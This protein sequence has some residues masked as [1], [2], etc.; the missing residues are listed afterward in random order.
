VDIGSADLEES[1]VVQAFGDRYGDAT[2]TNSQG[3][4]F[5]CREGEK[6]L[7]GRVKWVVFSVHDFLTLAAFRLFF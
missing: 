6:L 5:L 4:D 2:E 7:L 1:N 3:V